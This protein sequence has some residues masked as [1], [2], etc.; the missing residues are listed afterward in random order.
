MRRSETIASL[1]PGPRLPRWGQQLAFSLWPLGFIEACHRRYGDVVTI[2]G[3]VDSPVV[4][5]FNPELVKQVFRASPDQLRAGEANAVLGPL[6]GERS[7]FLLDGSEHVRQRRLLGPPFHGERMRSY[8]AVIRQAA[9]RAIDSWPVGEPFPLLPSMQSLTLDVMLAAVFGLPAGTRRE[10]CK[11]RLREMLSP[12]SGRLGM[13]AVGLSAGRWDGSARKRF[14]ERRQLVDELIYEEIA[15]RRAASDLEQRQDVLSLLAFARDEDGAAMTDGEVRDQ[16]VTLLVAGHATAATALAW[17]FDLLLRHPAVL[18]RL[19]AEIA[20][21]DG[22][23]LAAVVKETL[24][25]RPVVAGLVARRVVRQRPFELDGYV[26]PPGTEVSPAIAAIHRRPDLYPEPRTFRPERFLGPDAPDAYTWL[27]FGGGPRRCVGASFAAFEMGIVIRRILERADLTPAGPRPERAVG[28]RILFEP[29][30]GARVVQRQ[31]PRPARDAAPDPLAELERPFAH[32]L[33]VRGE[34]LL[35]RIHARPELHR[36]LPLGL[37]IRLAG[38]RGRL[39]WALPGARRL[40]LAR[41]AGLAGPGTSRDEIRRL[42]REHLVELA[43]Q[44]ELSWH[45]RAARR[46]PLHGLEHLERARAGGR[47][48]ILATVHMGPMLNLAYAVAA[49]GHPGYASG[50][51]TLED[52][53]LRG[54]AG[55]WWKTQMMWVEEAGCRW[56]G[57]GDSYSLLRALLERGELC[58]LN[59][60]IPGHS[61]VPVRLLGRTMEVGRGL[62][63]LALETGS[64]VVP[65]FTW[66][67]GTRQV[68]VLF[69]GID[70]REVADEQE[71]NARMAAA[72]EEALAPRLAQAH[73][74]L[75]TRASA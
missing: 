36:M 5:L 30:R 7:V 44:T 63:R 11:R 6:M 66:R 75:A 71:L 28:K 50:L 58:W 62:A 52:S 35:G 31:A 10:E 42:A 61:T 25:I 4:M 69:P 37:A 23:Y 48:A 2:T 38:A 68:G 1:P 17:A 59:W 24:R 15:L 72:V 73:R 20:E 43:I 47:G 54:H 46:M 16:L 40:A 64:P 8:E 26:L 74:G 57:R 32:L 19:Q 45:P 60:D 39:E 21:G 13:L 49:R 65:G 14:E 22:D 18:G 56:V 27:P 9:D 55:R 67:E 29:R 12:P 41:A 34:S 33:E 70:P 51:I 53:P 3:L